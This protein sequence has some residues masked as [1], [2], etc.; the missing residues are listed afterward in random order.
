[1]RCIRVVWWCRDIV[2]CGV[3][4]PCI[5]IPS[6]LAIS[7]VE[8]AIYLYFSI[9]HIC[10]VRCVL[11]TTQIGQHIVIDSRFINCLRWFN[12]HSNATKNREIH[13]SSI[14]SVLLRCRIATY[15]L[16]TVAWRQLQYGTAGIDKLLYT[17]CF[18]CVV[19]IYYNTK[20]TVM[21]Y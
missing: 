2:Q 1:M 12:T 7:T 3:L 8:V 15:H 20:Y 11:C 5:E 10:R 9:Q 16:R 21:Y 17:S 14:E 13:K 4:W 19:C 6:P 18:M